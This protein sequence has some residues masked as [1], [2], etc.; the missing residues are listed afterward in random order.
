[1]V[2][3]SS[4]FDALR[5]RRFLAIDSHIMDS[6]IYDYEDMIRDLITIFIIKKIHDYIEAHYRKLPRNRPCRETEAEFQA[7]VCRGQPPGLS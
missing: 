6:I 7:W 5:V 1:M 3:F 2:A 4:R